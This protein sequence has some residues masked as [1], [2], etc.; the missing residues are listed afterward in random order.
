MKSS[1]L[2]GENIMNM[3]LLSLVVLVVVGFT[4]PAAAQEATNGRVFDV[5]MT[6]G[7]TLPEDT[8]VYDHDLQLVPIQSVLDDAEYTVVVSGCLTC[9]IFRDA[10]QDVEAVY[11]DYKD[12]DVNFYFIYQ[13]LM[14]PENHGYV[15][16][17]SMEERFLQLDV[18]K[19]EYG[20]SIPWI[21]D[22]F[23]NDYKTLTGAPASEVVYDRSGKIVHS[24][25]TTRVPALRN[26]LIELVGDV[27][28][29]TQVAD[30]DFPD[31]LRLGL[32]EVTDVIE[33]VSFEGAAFPVTFEAE[34]SESTY[35]AKLRPEVN[36]ELMN[37]GTGQM[38]IGFHLDPIY[39]ANWNNLVAPLRYEITAP[40]GVSITPAVGQGIRPDVASDKNPREFLVDISNWQ[41][42]S[43]PMALDVYYFACNNDEGWCIPVTQ[44]YTVSLE[45]DTLGGSQRERTQMKQRGRAGGAPGQVPARPGA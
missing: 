29:H 30:L 31:V 21:L 2:I 36:A 7:N 37:T 10:Y 43:E 42:T 15:Q 39:G 25:S 28:H 27:E 45:R 17:F 44:R 11:H 24:A 38:Y 40:E 20:T 6:L 9:G 5:N 33:R 16:A 1:V 13:T 8:M 18:A 32:G 34:E 4:L 26:S 3:R 19:V 12:Q 22:T 23:N 41:D 35:F 14:H